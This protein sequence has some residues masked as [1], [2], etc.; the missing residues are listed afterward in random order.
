MVEGG[1]APRKREL[2]KKLSEKAMDGREAL[3]ARV[4]EQVTVLGP[5]LVDLKADI[6]A[7][8][9][10]FENLEPGETIMG[11]RTKK[12][13]CETYLNRTPR[14]V[15]FM[16]AGGYPA[17]ARRAVTVTAP[18]ADDRTAAE[19]IRDREA[20]VVTVDPVDVA[21]LVEARTSVEEEVSEPEPAVKEKGLAI[22]AALSAFQKSLRRGDE[23]EALALAWRMDAASYVAYVNEKG[24]EVLKID[25]KQSGQL[26]SAMRKVTSEDIGLA[27]FA[28]VREIRALNANWLKSIRGGGNKHE[29]WKLF[30]VH[31]V[32]LL[33][34]SGKSRLVDHACIVIGGNL[35]DVCD[36]LR[37][38]GPRSLPPYT[39]DGIHTGA[40]DKTDLG[41]ALARANFIAGE[42]AAAMPKAE[43]DDEYENEIF[44]AIREAVKS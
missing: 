7:L 6:D 17:S 19:I 9:L 5:K 8:W 33:Y 42:G 23:R 36:E 29:P 38:A 4:V 26:R 24:K 21:T 39:D 13:F 30:V 27:S 12:A 34:R 32:L 3:A 2:M 25:K 15:R 37:K 14:A 20:G 18:D 35:Q 10:E 28:L 43:I 11:C 22:F 1:N 16:L 40:G 31:A 44:E 41:K